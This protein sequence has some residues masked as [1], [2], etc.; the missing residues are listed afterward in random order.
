MCEKT[1]TKIDF[2]KVRNRIIRKRIHVRIEHV[3]KSRCQ[4]DYKQR[5]K[6][7]AEIAKWNKEHPDGTVVFVDKISNLFRS[8]TKN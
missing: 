8:K 2:K 4:E 3:K 6:Q 7:N 1:R 5:L